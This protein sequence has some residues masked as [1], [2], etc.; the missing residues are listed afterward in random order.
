MNATVG[1]SSADSRVGTYPEFTSN[2][3]PRIKKLGYNTIQLMAIMFVPFRLPPTFLTTGKGA[4]LLC[5][6]R[7][8]SDQ[9]LLR[10]FALRQV[11]SSERESRLTCV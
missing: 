8:S 11:F 7:V 1:I 4:R 9:L 5:E 2:I 6:L 10:I 3:L